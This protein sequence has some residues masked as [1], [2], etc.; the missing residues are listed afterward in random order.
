MLEN[1][2]IKIKWP[3]DLVFQ[4][5]RVKHTYTDTRKLIY[6]ILSVTIKCSKVENIY[7]RAVLVLFRNEVTARRPR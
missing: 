2:R 6:H 4:K 7:V 1:F 3:L 5:Q